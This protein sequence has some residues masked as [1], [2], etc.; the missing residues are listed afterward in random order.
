MLYLSFHLF[1]RLISLNTHEECGFIVGKNDFY[2]VIIECKNKS[3]EKNNFKIG[4]IDKLKLIYNSFIYDYNCFIIYHVH[5]NVCYPSIAD[6]DNSRLGE[7][8]LIIHDNCMYAY[9]I[10]KKKYAKKYFEGIKYIVV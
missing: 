4:F 5:K 6:L 9:R 10:V 1:N 8:I 3:K 2:N 7:I